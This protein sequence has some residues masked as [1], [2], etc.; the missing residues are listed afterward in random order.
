M[1]QVKGSAPNE[2]IIGSTV[3]TVNADGP[4][5]QVMGADT[6]IG[7][8]V[9]NTLGEDLDEI[10]EIMLDVVSGRIAYAVLSCGGFLGIGDKLFA[11]PWN[12]LK[13][14]T[15]NKRFVLDVAKQKL[16][17]APGFNKDQWPTMAES[18]WATSIHD[19]YGTRPYWE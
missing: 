12:A 16:K 9:V 10:K 11:V 7:D 14:D 6:L 18:T 13:L 15:A 3:A 4:G 17:D 5:P 1:T 19:Y 8:N 2:R